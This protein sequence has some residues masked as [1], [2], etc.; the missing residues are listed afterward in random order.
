MSEVPVGIIDRTVA[1]PTI[2]YL[3]TLRPTLS[4]ALQNFVIILPDLNYRPFL[5][6][7]QE[8]AAL[9][10]TGVT[11]KDLTVRYNRER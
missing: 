9:G 6:Y 8:M 1:N 3:D 11:L 5:F 7:T 2:C 4:N 10:F